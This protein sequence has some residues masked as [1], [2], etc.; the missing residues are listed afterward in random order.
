VRWAVLVFAAG[1]GRFGFDALGDA[2]ADAVADACAFGPWST[3][4]LL[5]G[6]I[7]SSVD[8]WG[9]APTL[10]ETM[11]AFYS[12]KGSAH[13]NLWTATRASTSDPFDAPTELDQI[14]TTVGERGPAISEDALTLI[15]AVDVGADHQLRESH[16]MTTAVMFSLAFDPGLG[17]AGGD[18][19]D[20]WLSADGNRL[21][22]ASDRDGKHQVYET[23]RTDRDSPFATPKLIVA[24]T[25]DPLYAPSLSADALDVYYVAGLDGTLDIYTA[26]R[27]AIDQPFGPGTAITEVNSARDDTYPRVSRDG[28]HMYLNYN[29]VVTGGQ[30]ADLYIATRACL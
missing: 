2:P 6:P 26:H 7:Q 3:P 17:I 18:D 27:S 11:L 13:A 16:R 25:A 9:G 8:D 23:T 30:N 22:F 21:V 19:D 24:A 1:C 10:G 14:S 5:P 15:W 29:A 12:Y 4:Q 28:R 20:A